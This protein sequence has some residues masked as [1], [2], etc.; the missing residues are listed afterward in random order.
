MKWD[1]CILPGK[2]KIRLISLNLSVNV[3]KLFFNL[4]NFIRSDFDIEQC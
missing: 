3:N 1:F 4:I 2:N